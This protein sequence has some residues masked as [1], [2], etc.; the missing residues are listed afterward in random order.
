[1]NHHVA[2]KKYLIKV[3]LLSLVLLGITETIINLAFLQFLYPTLD[4]VF[5]LHQ[6]FDKT[7]LSGLLGLSLKNLFWIVIW[8][9]ISLLPIKLSE[10]YKLYALNNIE[11]G[12]FTRFLSTYTEFT[13][14]EATLYIFSLV[15]IIIILVF[16][17]I[18]PFIITAIL[19]SILVSKKVREMEAIALNEQQRYEK[20]KSLLLS[21]IA[22]DLKTPITTISGYANVLLSEDMNIEN[23]QEYL[24]AIYHKSL[25]MND[26]ISL[27]FE[28]V[29][30]DST[31]FSLHL[32]I[33]NFSELV[34]G[35]VAAAYTDFEEKNM[36]L[37]IDIPDQDYYAQLDILHMQRA[38]SNVLTNAVKHNPQGT[39][40]T[41]K[42][43]QKEKN[44]I[45][46][47]LDD[48]VKIPDDMIAHIFDPFVQG[49]VSRSRKSGSGLGLS[50][51]KK[52][53][54]MH[55]GD[56]IVHQTNDSR[57]AYTKIFI[58]TIPVPQS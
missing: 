29:K 9:I 47:I 1:M 16:I 42:L 58:F 33:E 28:Y 51:S 27:L 4:Q 45:L 52:V 38:I 40:V 48:G 30:L 25:Q 11:N 37:G 14:K 31:G 55:H 35:C 26:I 20:Q 44:M 49:D 57:N 8:Q 54:N 50:I 32:K 12:V 17:W 19:F 13:D 23:T 3:F 43:R 24:Q 7:S 46:Q 34:R 18:L 36:N 22:H 5:M 39:T 15:S 41:V 53:L 21:D 56:L 6:L 10:P 2:F